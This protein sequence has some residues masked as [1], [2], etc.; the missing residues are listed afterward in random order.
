[1]ST[2]KGSVDMLLSAIFKSDEA[3]LEHSLRLHEVIRDK[4]KRDVS[5]YSSGYKCKI[6]RECMCIKCLKD[7]LFCHLSMSFHL[8]SL[9]LGTVL[10]CSALSSK[11]RFCPFI[12]RKIKGRSVAASTIIKDFCLT[13]YSMQTNIIIFRHKQQLP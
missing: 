3:S 13:Y 9:S 11:L 12:S 1:M 2:N 4:D 6:K 7:V 8:F 5:E 10:R